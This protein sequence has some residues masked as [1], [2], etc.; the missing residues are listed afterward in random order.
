MSRHQAYRNYDYEND[1]D[2]YEGDDYLD[3][4]EE[5]SPE[6]RA[7]LEAG[8]AEIRAALGNE[9][10]K[11]TPQ[12]IQE[13]LWHY[14][15]DVDKSIAYLTSKFIAPPV[16]KPVKGIVSDKIKGESPSPDD[17]VLTAQSQ[18]SLLAKK[19]NT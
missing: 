5:L 14:Y 3:E 4:E 9:S 2:E 10:S 12:Q 13:A 8:T 7:Q 17:V 1:L 18:G 15:Y 16:Q 11:I 19:V 6:D